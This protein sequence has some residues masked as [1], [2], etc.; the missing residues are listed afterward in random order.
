M[1]YIAVPD[2]RRGP[3]GGHHT[4]SLP[5]LSGRTPLDLVLYSAGN[6]HKSTRQWKWV[7]AGPVCLAVI[8]LAARQV[9]DSEWPGI[10][11]IAESPWGTD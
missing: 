3:R 11:C 5:E 4:G 9:I 2:R 1:W 10:E 7:S 8:L 6:R